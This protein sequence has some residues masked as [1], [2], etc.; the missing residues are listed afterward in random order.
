LQERTVGEKRRGRKRS[1]S[2]EHKYGRGKREVIVEAKGDQG[3]QVAQEY[4]RLEKGERKESTKRKEK[5]VELGE[6]S[7]SPVGHG[8]SARERNMGVDKR[9]AK[10]RAD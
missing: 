2:V 8:V 4:V 9:G 1:E 7:F 5:G 10:R 3:F 6:T